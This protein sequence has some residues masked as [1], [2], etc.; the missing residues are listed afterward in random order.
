VPLLAQTS[1]ADKP[2][3]I[4]LTSEDFESL[5]QIT[6]GR[7]GTVLLFY[8]D[9]ATWADRISGAQWWKPAE[10]PRS[11]RRHHFTPRALPVP[12][13]HERCAADGRGTQPQ[14][15]RYSDG[16]QASRGF[17]AQLHPPGDPIGQIISAHNGRLIYI[18]VNN[19]GW[20]RVNTEY[21]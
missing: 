6:A 5:E 4:E 8:R 18:Q 21:P 2:R 15:C 16:G 14:P 3:H 10:R 12:Y 19:N 13:G 17:D 9:G 1:K 20:P 11:A 7:T